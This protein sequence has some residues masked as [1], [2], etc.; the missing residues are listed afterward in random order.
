M[1]S[2]IR[3]LHIIRPEPAGSLGGADLH[4]VDLCAAQNQTSSVEAEILAP[5]ASPD[6]LHRA[7]RA[8]VSVHDPFRR[9]RR[10]WRHMLAL[11]TK[12]SIDLIHA[13]GYEA[14][15]LAALLPLFQPRWRH[16]PRVMTCHG[17][18]RASLK[19]TLM[20]HLDMLCMRRAH[21]LI[22]VSEHG[23]SLLRMAVPRTPVHI[24]PNGVVL[25]R[26][27]PDSSTVES[28]RR[29]LGATGNDVVIGFVGRLST[30]KRPDLF[31]TAAADLVANR[32]ELKFAIV[33]GGPLEQQLR[34]SVRSSPAANRMTFAGLR[35][36]MDRVFAALDVLVVPSDTEGTPRVVLEAQAHGVPVIGT[37][38][39]DLPT[40]IE[41][42]VTGLLVP[43]GEPHHLVKALERLVGDMSLRQRLA[44]RALRQV[45]SASIDAMA[46]AVHATYAEA[47]RYAQDPMM[48]ARF[49]SHQSER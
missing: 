42:D 17:L 10:R 3:V 16:L 5:S 22:A 38:V 37:S 28:V 48:P 24:V 46:A 32:P 26:V 25:P 12:L 31:L 33:G 4:V 39:G 9:A 13:H 34:R 44:Q 27:T 18:V 35:H 20:S 1:T 15:Y 11:P 40:L 41:Q 43:P 14:D 8:N 7:H 49:P 30:E 23:A 47:L 36:D 45:E 29:G 19:T 2:V 21:A 6:F